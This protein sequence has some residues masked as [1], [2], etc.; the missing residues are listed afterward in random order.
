MGYFYVK[1]SALA[2]KVYSKKIK[3]G[4]LSREFVVNKR[5]TQHLFTCIYNNMLRKQKTELRK[6]SW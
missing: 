5:N 1:D 3:V 2:S 6:K 4:F